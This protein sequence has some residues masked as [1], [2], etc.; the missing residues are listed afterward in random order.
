MKEFKRFFTIFGNIRNIVNASHVI[1]NFLDNIVHNFK[2]QKI[3]DFK[4][5][6]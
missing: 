1:T 6:H 5:Q 4:G 3:N 2:A